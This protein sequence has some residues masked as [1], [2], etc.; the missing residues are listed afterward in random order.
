MTDEH[1]SLDKSEESMVDIF[2]P[3]DEVEAALVSEA[4]EEAGIH[5]LFQ[6]DQDKILLGI[7]DGEGEFGVVRVLEEDAER[8]IEVI[9]DALPGETEVEMVEDE[10]EDGEEEEEEDDE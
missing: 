4:L 2:H 6:S 5:Y 8:A 10:E 7:A 3:A 1:A 9:Q